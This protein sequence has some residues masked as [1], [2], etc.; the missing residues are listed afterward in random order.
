MSYRRTSAPAQR[1]PLCAHA[2]CEQPLPDLVVLQEIES[3]MA[4]RVFNERHL[5]GHYTQALLVDSRDYRQIDIRVLAGPA[6]EIQEVRTHADLLGRGSDSSCPRDPTLLLAGERDLSTPIERPRHEA[7]VAPRAE[8][9]VVPDAMH[10]LQTRA[11][12]DSARE[13]VYDLL[14]A[15][16]PPMQAAPRHEF[17]PSTHEL[18]KVGQP[19]TAAAGVVPRYALGSLTGANAGGPPMRA[20]APGQSVRWRA[21]HP[22]RASHSHGE[23]PS[24]R[25]GT[26]A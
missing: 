5:G 1:R 3:L 24:A 25:V 18:S 17:V 12:D 22:S 21:A 7:K 16:P 26:R 4:L 6:V 14:T 8:V 10:S 13:A 2:G 20:G 9:L 23:P 11:T 15:W 19:P